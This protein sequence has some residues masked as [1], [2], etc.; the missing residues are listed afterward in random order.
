MQNINFRTLEPGKKITVVTAWAETETFEDVSN[1]HFFNTTIE[2][3]YFE[4]RGEVA[5]L[6]IFAKDGDGVSRRVNYVL[7]DGIV[8][9]TDVVVNLEEFKAESEMI[10]LSDRKPEFVSALQ[11][12]EKSNLEIYEDFEHDTFVVVNRSNNHEYRVA[13]QSKDG[14]VFAKCTC[15]DFTNRKRICKHIGETLA[16][17]MFGQL[18]RIDA[19]AV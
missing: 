17:R 7:E 4:P 15:A 13:L 18:A 5:F 3:V 9:S 6:R 14:A 11:R 1:G 8:K 2:Q 16:N 19:A 12:A 10:C